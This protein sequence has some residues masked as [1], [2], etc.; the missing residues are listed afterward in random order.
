VRA[1][2]RLLL[3]ALIAAGAPLEA[4]EWR[5]DGATSSAGFE[6]PVLRFFSAHG[7]FRDLS[8]TL[9]WDPASHELK[10]SARIAAATLEMGSESQTRWAKSKDF[11]D[12]ERF[13]EIVFESEPVALD[14]LREGMSIAGRLTLHGQTRPVRLELGACTCALDAGGPCELRAGTRV[15]RADFDLPRYRAL[16]GDEVTLSLDVLARPEPES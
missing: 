5:V 12:V 10:V 16:V 6:L 11:L 13:P 2:R 4:R 1:P 7:R 15:A 8:G 14:T 3:L 9:S